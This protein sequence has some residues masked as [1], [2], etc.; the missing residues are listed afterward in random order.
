M[1]LPSKIPKPGKTWMVLAVAISIGLLAALGARHYFSNRIAQIDA[2]ASS[3]M[4]KVVVAKVALHK[5][6]VVSAENVAVRP[7]PADYAHATSVR[8]DEFEH[9]D[10]ERVGYDVE[11]GEAILWGLLE[12]KKLPTFSAR[13]VDGRRAVT[14]PV[15]E[16]NSISG[17]LEPGDT[18]DLMVSLDRMGRKTA[19]P[20][21]QG[22]RVMAT[23]QRSVDDPKTG[24]ARQY[25]TVTLDTT[26][27]EARTIILA[28]EAGRIT[29][30]L[31]NPQDTRSAGPPAD[32]D[33][34]LYG[35]PLR[36]LRRAEAHGVP[37]LYGGADAHFSA[38]ALQLKPKAAVTATEIQA[39][40]RP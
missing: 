16:I 30:L 29:A 35:P 21:L 9:L 25:E 27:A 23:G 3:R 13:I 15:D 12:T 20:L 11:P 14:V 39:E 8:P 4:V 5:G 22:L 37:V 26:P 18:I 40:G 28:R 36:P 1:K 7:I 24:E 2:D 38:S 34:L 17:M 33:S 31:R 32:I 6:D 19:A 10:G